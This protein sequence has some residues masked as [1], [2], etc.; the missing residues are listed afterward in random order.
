M[1]SECGL[2]GPCMRSVIMLYAM[3]SNQPSMLIVTQL[4][5]STTNNVLIFT[6]HC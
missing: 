5:F 2:C 1:T 4:V 3:W 6:V